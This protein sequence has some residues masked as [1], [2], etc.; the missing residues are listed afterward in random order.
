M[1]G[2]NL[3]P[4]FIEQPLTIELMERLIRVERNVSA[5]VRC[6]KCCMAAQ[7]SAKELTWRR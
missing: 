4:G 6:R 2:L 3:G 7:P 5:I 1:L